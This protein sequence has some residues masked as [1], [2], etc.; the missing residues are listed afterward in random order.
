MGEPTEREQYLMRYMTG[1]L[2]PVEEI[3]PIEEALA[4]T[5]AVSPVA[6]H[7]TK[8]LDDG[9]CVTLLEVRG[10]LESLETILDAHPTVHE[11][12][13]AGEREG[14][15]YLQTE[16]HELTRALI[17]MQNESAVIIRMPIEHTGDGGIRGTVLGDDDAFQRVLERFPDAVDVEIESIGE[18]HP[19]VEDVFATLTDRQ[20][21]ILATAILEGYYEDPRHASQQDIAASLGIAPGT[22]SEHLRRIEAKVFSEYILDLESTDGQSR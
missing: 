9:T 7:Q 5:P 1:V 16:P 22:V 18:Y 8:L 15:V 14:F 21:E 13:I 4:E 19:N 20:R 6:I 2:R 12:T 17:R 11:Y 10:D 3:H